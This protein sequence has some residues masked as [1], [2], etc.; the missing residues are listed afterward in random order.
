MDTE[1]EQ[2]KADVADLQKRVRA[3]EKAASEK[4]AR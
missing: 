3:L 2:L 1:K 4:K